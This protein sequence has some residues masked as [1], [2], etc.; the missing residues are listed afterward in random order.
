MDKT[1]YIRVLE[2]L[3]SYLF[4]LRPRRFGKSLLVSM[5]IH[6]YGEQHRAEFENLFGAYDIGKN[7]TPLAHSYLTLLFEFSGVNTENRRHVKEGFLFRLKCW[8]LVITGKEL[9]YCKEV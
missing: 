8:V 6:Y 9:T 4:F 1:P 5:L 2:S 3:S 7:P